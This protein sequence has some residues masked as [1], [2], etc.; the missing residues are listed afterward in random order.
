MQKLG[1]QKAYKS[2]SQKKT[3]HRCHLES[4]LSEEATAQMTPRIGTI[5]REATA[6]KLP[7][8][9]TV[10]R[11]HSTDD[12][13]NRNYQKRSHSTEATSKCN[14]QKKPQHRWPTLTDH[15][16]RSLE[17]VVFSFSLPICI[18]AQMLVMRSVASCHIRREGALMRSTD[19]ERW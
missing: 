2:N 1:C 4:E 7:R 16:K 14:C 8:N 15:R 11:S 5:R 13:S 6:Q 3:Q 12:T 19:E 10:R 18:G 9:A 17:D